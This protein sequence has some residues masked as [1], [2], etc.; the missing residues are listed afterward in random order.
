M[1]YNPPYGS[2]DPDASYVDKDVPGAVAGSKVPKGAVEHPQRE[3]VNAIVLAGIAPL[4]ADLTQLDQAIRR[5][6]DQMWIVEDTTYTV[7]SDPGDDFADLNQALDFLKLKLILEKVTVT[8]A[9]RAETHNYATDIVIDHTTG[10]RINI[11]GAAMTGAVP[12]NADFVITGHTAGQRAADSG[13]HLTMLNARYAT[14]LQLDGCSIVVRGGGLGLLDKVLVRGDGTAFHGIFVDG[15]RCGFG[16]VSIHGFGQRG[17]HAQSADLRGQGSVSASG[18]GSFGFGLDASS[19][20]GGA[21]IAYSNA[22]NGI[23][24]IYGS[25]AQIGQQHGRGNGGHGMSIGGATVRMNNLAVGQFNSNAIG[26][27]SVDDTG[28]MILN[29]FAIETLN[30]GASGTIVEDGSTLYGAGTYITTTGNGGAGIDAV[31]CGDIILADLVANNN[32]GNGIRA[33]RG[34]RVLAPTGGANGNGATDALADADSF[35]DLTGGGA[36]TYSP[37]ANTVGNA[38]SYIKTV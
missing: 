35:I 8:L 22:S 26:G 5:R 23:A 24:Y 14:K 3:I 33:S 1:R 28:R 31:K 6:V 34:S 20:Y 25:S 32:G 9:L 17:L 7:G 16:D 12:G 10:H 15:S 11:V 37:A 27:V 19:V 29:T 30:N 18:C 38:N 2:V 13:N 4:A 36:G 21:L